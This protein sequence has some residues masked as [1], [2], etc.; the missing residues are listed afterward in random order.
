[1]QRHVDYD[2]HTVEHKVPQSVVQHNHE[3]LQ[4][5]LVIGELLLTQS[6]VAAEIG[7][8]PHCLYLDLLVLGR[9]QEML[10]AIEHVCSEFSS[11]QG[12]LGVVVVEDVRDATNSVQHKLFVFF[13]G[14]L[15]DCVA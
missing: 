7:Q 10:D 3:G 15:V 14:P 8:H 12:L 4:E 5:L 6:A 11:Q 13:D 9:Q 2:T 1:M